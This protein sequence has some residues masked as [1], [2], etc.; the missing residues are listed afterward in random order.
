MV[1][2]TFVGSVCL[3]HRHTRAPEEGVRGRG[4]ARV[5]VGV[6]VRVG[7]GARVRVRLRK[8]TMLSR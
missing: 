3:E 2:V 5:G 8:V 6:G 1:R 7:V 4:R